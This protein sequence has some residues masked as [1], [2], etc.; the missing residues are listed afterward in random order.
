MD[1]IDIRDTHSV[2]AGVEAQREI[3]ETAD[4]MG[5]C[6]TRTSAPSATR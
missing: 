4:Q 3:T 5:A 1:Q 2:I 6:G